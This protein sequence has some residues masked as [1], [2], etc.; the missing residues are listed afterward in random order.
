MTPL[1]LVFVLE[2]NREDKSDA[3]YLNE[4]LNHFYV[5]ENDRYSQV[6]R[7]NI[8]L[9][10]KGKYKSVKNRLQN[11]MRIFSKEGVE[12]KVIY[13]IDLDS[14]EPN[15]K[16]GTLNRNIMDYCENNGYDLIWMC[17]NVENVFLGLEPSALDDKTEAAKDW[18]R[19]ENK[20]LNAVKLSK[21]N[22]QKCCSNILLILDKYL[23]RK[24]FGSLHKTG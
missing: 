14:N 8:F 5:F 4:V 13:M 21:T 19:N 17:E 15:Y 7:Q 18:A 6:S 10:G 9:E 16:K 12:S 23:K 2:C 11:E 3:I 22:I 1:R 20:E 24:L